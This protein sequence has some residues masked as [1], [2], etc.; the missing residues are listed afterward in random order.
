MYMAGI[1][2]AIDGQGEDQCNAERA[3]DDEEP[4]GFLPFPLLPALDDQLCNQAYAICSQDGKQ[5]IAE[6]AKPDI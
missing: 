6:G 2:I 5:N 1:Q 3:A 4:P